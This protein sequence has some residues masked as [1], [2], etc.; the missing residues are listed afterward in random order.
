[1]TWH[2]FGVSH[3]HVKTFQTKLQYPICFN[4]AL[5]EK[6][7]SIKF[8]RGSL[9][10]VGNFSRHKLDRF[11]FYKKTFFSTGKNSHF[12]T[13]GH[14]S[15]GILSRLYTGTHVP[16]WERNPRRKDHQIF[17]QLLYSLRH[18]GFCCIKTKCE[19]I[20]S[21]Q[22]VR[23]HKLLINLEINT[24]L[25]QASESGGIPTTLSYQSVLWFYT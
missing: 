13:P 2:L 14:Y 25:W 17:T 15:M 8:T 20:T 12:S 11:F 24:A 5:P 23:W 6:L 19:N 10:Y 4:Q 22:N 21:R 3:T 7:S 16:Q 9:S 18:T 1:M